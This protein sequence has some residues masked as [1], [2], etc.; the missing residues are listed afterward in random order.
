MV[1][2]VL[3][4]DQR[5]NHPHFPSHRESR[6]SSKMVGKVEVLIIGAGWTSDFLIPLLRG[7]GIS[8]SATTR[9][10]RPRNGLRTI[11]FV[12]DE[13]DTSDESG[14]FSNLPYADTVIITFPIKKQGASTRF[15][16]LWEKSH[17]PLQDSAEVLFVQLGSTGIYDVCVIKYLPWIYR[18]IE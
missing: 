13:N 1:T 5:F 6:K 7:E 14:P 12:F 9:D 2:R 16:T 17:P 4:D 8:C 3:L 15:L 18:Y 11:P 10:G